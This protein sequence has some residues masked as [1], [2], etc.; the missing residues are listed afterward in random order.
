MSL[1]IFHLVFIALSI[2][3]AAF[4]AAWATSQ[5]RAQHD[6]T[7]AIAAVLC[8]IAAAGLMVYAARFQRKTK[9]LLAMALALV[10]TPR[11]AF[12]CPVCFGDSNSP[13]ASAANMGI[14]VMLIITVCML[15]GFASFFIY[16][17]RRARLAS[18]VD[19][20][21][22]EVAGRTQEGTAQC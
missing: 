15:A 7:Y 8:L 17:M 19:A 6:I 1:R 14:L 12:A 21:A 10:A 4:V 9:H 16:L 18:T 11:S 13:L 22:G 3:L 20:G 5:Y 2:V